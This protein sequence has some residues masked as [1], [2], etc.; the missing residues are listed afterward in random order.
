MKGKIEIN[1]EVCKGCGLCMD[2][3]PKG[4]IEI[5]DNL[6]K[7]GYYPAQFKEEHKT[8]QEESECTG[9]AMCALTCPDIA[10][11]VYRAEKSDKESKEKA[12]A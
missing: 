7:K 4:Q 2:V 9:C 12:E 6:N 10:I 8:E 1:A 11:E 5:S 3:C